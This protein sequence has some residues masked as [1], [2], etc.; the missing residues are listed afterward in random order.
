MRIFGIGLALF[1]G[2]YTESFAAAGWLGW[3][4][5]VALIAIA[6][7]MVCGRRINNKQYSFRDKGDNNG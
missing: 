7:V 5:Y 3:V 2:I 6:V 1:T 4:L